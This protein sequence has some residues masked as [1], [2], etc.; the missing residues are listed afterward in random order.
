LNISLCYQKQ[1]KPHLVITETSKILEIS[2]LPIPSRIK[3]LFRRGT[4]HLVEGEELLALQDLQE[5][6]QLDGGKDG[7]VT[8]E[9][10]AVKQ[11]IQAKKDSER[12]A[13]AKLFA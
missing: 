11:K 4:A 3:A 8:K 10:M 12:K 6:Y 7:L 5:A 1:Q 9:Y 2:P 13:Y